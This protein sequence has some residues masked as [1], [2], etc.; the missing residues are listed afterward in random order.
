MRRN[1]PAA[2]RSFDEALRLDP[3]SFDAL[4]GLTAL[5]LS[6]GR[7]AEARARVDREIARYPRHVDRLLLGAQTYALLGHVSRAEELLKS[8]IAADPGRTEPYGTLAHFYMQQNR[9][10]DGRRVFEQIV[11][12]DPRPVGALTMIGIILRKQNRTEEAVEYYRRALA[13]D[14]DA[15][16]AANNLAWIYADQG[17]LLEEGLRLARVARSRLPNQPE[18]V[19]T[20]GWLYYKSRQPQLAVPYLK[21]AIDLSPRNPQY[22]YHLAA[23]YARAGETQLARTTLQE[24]MKLGTDFPEA[25][26]AR[27]LLA[28]LR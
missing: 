15:A 21:E 27:R 12:R 9:L 28:R 16:V 2:R 17:Q 1:F 19:D 10:D 22:R 23:T 3:N 7:K 13:I 14:A 25:E 20:I 26:E 24:A 4:A 5:D 18:V 11:D 6:T 8:A